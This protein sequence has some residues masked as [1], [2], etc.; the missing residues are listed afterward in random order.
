MTNRTKMV[1]KNK[2]SAQT[3]TPRT[4]K[5]LNT[6]EAK[7]PAEPTN[8]PQGL[9]VVG[10]GAS[11][12]GLSALNSFFDALS[13]DTGLAFLVI[14]HLHRSYESHLAKLLQQHTQIPTRQVSRRI[15][16]EAD[17]VYII[18]P[19]RN[20]IMTDTHLETA[21]L[22]EPRGKRTPIDHFFRSLA[23]VIRQTI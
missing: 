13:P 20:I 16:V 6:L 18:P 11:A 17:H 14:T 19:N 12:G 1:S 3:S 5:K 21:E 23:S 8:R 4:S 10:I 7:K 2:K 9:T 22:T 15:K